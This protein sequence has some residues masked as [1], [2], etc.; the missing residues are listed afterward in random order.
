MLSVCT[1]FSDYFFLLL[2][3]P[4]GCKLGKK[5]AFVL[6][7]QVAILSSHISVPVK[8]FG[9]RSWVFWEEY[10]IWQYQYDSNNPLLISVF[11]GKHSCKSVFFFFYYFIVSR[12]NHEVVLWIY[13]HVHYNEYSLKKAIVIWSIDYC[14][15]SPWNSQSLAHRES[16]TNIAKLGCC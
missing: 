15:L 8:S 16:S 5:K 13:L 1:H 2:F 12:D 7:Q 11:K 6:F 3:L 10:L 14:V 9:N 4:L